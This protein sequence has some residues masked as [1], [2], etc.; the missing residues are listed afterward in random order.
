MSDVSASKDRRQYNAFNALHY[1]LVELLAVHD[2]QEFHQWVE[3]AMVGV[4]A[5]KRRDQLDNNFKQQ[6]E[7]NVSKP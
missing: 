2:E 6:G 1:A 7:Q 4:F 3:V 5:E